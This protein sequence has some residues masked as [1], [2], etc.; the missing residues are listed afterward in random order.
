MDRNRYMFTG[1]AAGV[2]LGIA[3]SIVLL[4]AMIAADFRFGMKM[5]AAAAIAVCIPLCLLFLRHKWNVRII[6]R[7]MTAVSFLITVYYGYRTGRVPG[8][9]GNSNFFRSVVSASAFLHACMITSAEAGLR[10]VSKRD[11]L[12]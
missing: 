9:E 6:F 11:D 10:I 5:I 8:I 2:I 3:V 4:Q 7:I 12:C 1:I